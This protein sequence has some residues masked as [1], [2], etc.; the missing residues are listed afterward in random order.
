V[1]VFGVLVF[2]VCVFCLVELWSGWC[3]TEGMTRTQLAETY[4]GR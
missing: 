1:L 2:G 4:V 3:L